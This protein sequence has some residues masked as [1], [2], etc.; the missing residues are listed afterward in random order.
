MERA[1]ALSSTV[2]LEV[3]EFGEY[4]FRIRRVE[5]SGRGNLESWLVPR[6]DAELFLAAANDT[7][8]RVRALLPQDASATEVSFMA[9]TRDLSFRFRGLEFARQVECQ[10]YCGLGDDRGS[11]HGPDAPEIAQLL[12]KLA[13][14]RSCLTSD[15]N[16]PL[17]RAAPERWLE[18][19]VRSDPPKLDARSESS[20]SSGK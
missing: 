6:R 10:M 19:I 1:R 3:Y 16:N 12:A 14:K 4:D 20:F 2:N 7:I 8:N 18:T 11:V 15:T 9:G 13:E 17:Y 5:A